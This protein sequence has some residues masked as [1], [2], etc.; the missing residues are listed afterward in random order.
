[1]IFAN[2]FDMYTPTEYLQ[3]CRC[4]RPRGKILADQDFKF[5]LLVVF[6]WGMCRFWKFEVDRGRALSTVSCK[7]VI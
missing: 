3:F 2:N 5:W 6:H 1:M 7:H 4:Q